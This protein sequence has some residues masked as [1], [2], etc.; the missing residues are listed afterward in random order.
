MKH[1]GKIDVYFLLKGCA[2]KYS[3]NSFYS[4]LSS[5]T[6][7]S[8]E[9]QDNDDDVDDG[10]DDDVDDDVDEAAE[11]DKSDSSTSFQVRGRLQKPK[12]A[13]ASIHPG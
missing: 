7:D 2:S 11:Q 6:D 5:D 3:V 9:D 1:N 4:E 8:D 13:T 12:K 10:A